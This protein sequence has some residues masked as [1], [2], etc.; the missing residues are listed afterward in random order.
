MG[1]LET[2]LIIQLYY[3]N[4]NE[5]YLI[6]NENEKF[7]FD[8]LINYY[9]QSKNISFEDNGN[10]AICERNQVIDESEIENCLDKKFIEKFYSF[11]NKYKEKKAKNLLFF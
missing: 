3:I 2:S 7:Q 1:K 5:R 8:K 11:I 10:Y 9:E 6:I 4:F